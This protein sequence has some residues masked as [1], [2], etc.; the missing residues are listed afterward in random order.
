M[1][2]LR[3]REFKQGD[4]AAFRAL[5][6]EWIA[7]AGGNPQQGR[8]DLFYAAR[9][10]ERGSDCGLLRADCDGAGRV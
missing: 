8:A 2:K 9:G 4:A 1:T 6:V 7:S 5:N 10:G 3:L